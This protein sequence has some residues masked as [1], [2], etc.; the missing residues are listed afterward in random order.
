MINKAI[1]KIKEEIRREN[2]EY[3]KVIGEFLISKVEDETTAK[4]ILKD[5]KSI[6]KS[7]DFMKEKAKA[8]AQ[9]GCAILTDEEGFKIVLEYFA[10]NL[11]AT[12]EVKP[13]VAPKSTE[14]NISLDDLF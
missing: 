7:L 4:A 5:D 6:V 11:N 8:K 1:E 12:T 13:P 9:N 3:V 14:F 2:N 10:I